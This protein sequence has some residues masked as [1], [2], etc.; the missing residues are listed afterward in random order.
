MQGRVRNRRGEYHSIEA[1]LPQGV[2]NTDRGQS[3]TADMSTRSGV[4]RSVSKAQ[5]RLRTI[6]KISK[7]RE[8]KIKKEFM[9][10][11]EELKQED[12]K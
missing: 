12:E 5:D 10:L 11:E 6:E 7:Y 3:M 4:P 1:T 8:D 2:L 9:K